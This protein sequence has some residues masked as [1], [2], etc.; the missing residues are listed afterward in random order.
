MACAKKVLQKYKLPSKIS[1]RINTPWTELTCIRRYI[2][3][4]CTDNRNHV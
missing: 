3:L 1:K 2:A 4:Y